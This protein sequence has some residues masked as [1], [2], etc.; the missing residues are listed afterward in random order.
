MVESSFRSVFPELKHYNFG[1]P[2]LSTLG[3]QPNH[4]GRQDSR[5]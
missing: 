5:I 2:D 1:S 4:L 3:V